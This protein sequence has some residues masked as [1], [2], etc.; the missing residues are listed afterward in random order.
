[1]TWESQARKAR[2]FVRT[3]MGGRICCDANR[4]ERATFAQV[5]VSDR[6]GGRR[7]ASRHLST[8]SRN[9][10]ARTH[11]AH[12]TQRATR[13]MRARGRGGRCPCRPTGPTQ[14]THAAPRRRGESHLSGAQPNSSRCAR[15]LRYQ[16]PWHR[17]P[18]RGKARAGP[19]TGRDQHQTGCHLDPGLGLRGVR[20]RGVGLD[21]DQIRTSF[22]PGLGKWVVDVPGWHRTCPAATS[23]WGTS[24]RDAVALLE[25][26]MNN[27]PL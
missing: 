20:R 11:H 22:E 2:G 1:V 15:H 26:S 7:A 23:T 8:R 4:R 16:H 21:R 6:Q 18:R 17:H 12:T 13:L 5:G 10:V 24:R 14:H 9:P 3:Q 27:T 19:A 25:A